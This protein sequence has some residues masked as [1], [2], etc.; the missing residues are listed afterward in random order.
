MSLSSEISHVHEPRSLDS[1]VTFRVNADVYNSTISLTDNSDSLINVF[2]KLDI[3][4][5][6]KVFTFSQLVNERYPN[7][8]L[9]V[10]NA[11]IGNSE[12]SIIS[13]W[14]KSSP[15][16]LTMSSNIRI[17]ALEPLQLDGEYILS[18]DVYKIGGS[19][20]KGST[21][22]S[23]VM[24]MNV[25]SGKSIQ[26][27]ANIVYPDRHIITNIEGTKN[28]NIYNAM[29]EMR[30]DADKNVDSRISV[31]GRG[32]ISGLN[33]INASITV[34]Y[35]RRTITFNVKH[36]LSNKMTSHIDFQWEQ[37]KL[38]VVDAA[39]GDYSKPEGREIIGSLKVATPFNDFKSMEA[40]V[41][42]RINNAMYK[43]QID[44]SWN[45]NKM[46]STTV[47][48]KKPF[49]IYNID[50][51]VIAKAT[52]LGFKTIQASLVHRINN[53]LHTVGKLN[54]NKQ[55]AQID[56][57]LS[58]K[59]DDIYSDIK[60]QVDIKTTFTDLREASA[61]FSHKNNGIQMTTDSKLQYNKQQYSLQSILSN[62][63]SVGHITVAIPDNVLRA[64]WTHSIINNEIVSNTNIT[65]GKNQGIYIRFNGMQEI[66]LHNVKLRSSVTVS[67]KPEQT[68][69][70]D[71]SF[72]RTTNN[73]IDAIISVILPSKQTV[74]L[75]AKK[76]KQNTEVMS[77]ASLEYKTGQIIRVESFH[78]L[79]DKKQIKLKFSSP[80]TND[81]TAEGIL[82]TSINNRMARVSIDAEPFLSKWSALATFDNTNGINYNLKI[83]TPYVQYA[84]SQITITSAMTEGKRQSTI[85]IEYLPG[86]HV[87]LSSIYYCNNLRDIHM[88]V[89]L[90][91]T[92]TQ[93]PYASVSFTHKGD[94]REFSSSAEME[95][96]HNTKTSGVITFSANDGLR[97]SV[98]IK[99]PFSADLS[100][101]F[102][103]KGSLNSFE[104]HGEIQWGQRY[105][106][107]LMHQGSLS[108]FTS[109]G[110]LSLGGDIYNGKLTFS[111][112]P[113]LS[114]EISIKTPIQRFE[115]IQLSHSFEG[116]LRKFS[117]HTELSS[118][119]YGTYISDIRLDTETGLAA[120][121]T[122]QTPIQ[123]Y[124]Y[125]KAALS[126]VG[127]LDK[128]VSH[129][130]V[131]NG[132]ISYAAD[133]KVSTDPDVNI[134]MSVETP[135]NEFKT[136][137]IS[138]SH[139][140]VVNDFK[141]QIET[142][143]NKDIFEMNLI[144]S[145][146]D[147]WDIDLVI[148]SPYMN[149]IKASFDHMG[150]KKK[151][152]SDFTFKY[153]KQNIQSNIKFQLDPS[154]NVVISLKSPFELFKHHELT[155]THA[156]GLDSFK[157]NMQYKCNGKT[158]IGD[159]SFQNLNT[160]RAEL[161]VKLPAFP[162]IN[163][164]V[165]HDGQPSNFKCL[166]SMSY[167]KNNIQ[168][169]T[170]FNSVNGIKG[171]IALKTPFDNMQSISASLSHSGHINNF[172]SQGEV[173]FNERIGRVD[174]TV[175][176]TKNIS[177]IVAIKTPFKGFEDISSTF[178]HTGGIYNFNS[179]VVYTLNGKR[180]EGQV[181]FKNDK[182]VSGSASLKSD[183]PY[184]GIYETLITYQGNTAKFN[185]HGSINM[186]KIVSEANI[187]FDSTNGYVGSF[188]IDS[189]HLKNIDMAFT[190]LFTTSSINSNA[191]ITYNG[192]KL[193]E[194]LVD[195]S[196]KSSVSGIVRLTTSHTG[197][198]ITE[199]SFN[200]NGNSH[201]VQ[202]DAKLQIFNENYEANLMLTSSPN[203]EAS[204]TIKSPYTE[205]VDLK[206]DHSSTYPNW[207]TVWD[208]S[209]GGQSMFN[210]D[211]S[212]NFELKVAGTIKLSTPLPGFSL[213]S[214]TFSHE[215]N[216][217]NFK[218]H[219][220]VT[221][222]TQSIIADLEYSPT[223]GGLT[224]STPF[225]QDIKGSFKIAG[226][227]LNSKSSITLNYGPTKLVQISAELNYP[228]F[229]ELILVTALQGYETSRVTISRQTDSD[230]GAKAEL[231]FRGQNHEA[232]IRLNLDREFSGSFVIA[233]PLLP[234]L[235]SRFNI[236]MKP[237][238]FHSHI[239]LIHDNKK[240]EV[241]TRFSTQKSI[242]GRFTAIS[243]L[244]SDFTVAFNT[245]T[246][247]ASLQSTAEASYG[248]YK[249]LDISSVLTIA[250]KMSFE[251]TAITPNIRTN[252]EM[253]LH[254]NLQDFTVH[255]KTTANGKTLEGD[256][257]VRVDPNIVGSL[258]IVTPFTHPINA[259]VS[260][261]GQSTNFKGFAEIGLMNKLSSCEVSLNTE[262]RID[263][264]FSL[265]S[266]YI[267]P[268]SAAVEHS[269][270]IN[271]F[272][273]HAEVTLD[274]EAHSV[275]ASFD[276]QGGLRNF[277]T[278]ASVA[279]DNERTEAKIMLDIETSMTGSA[280][281][282][283]PQNDKMTMSF[284][285]SGLIA[286]FKNTFMLKSNEQAIL[287][288]DITY[289]NNPL[290][291]SIVLKT[292]IRG[293]ETLSAKYTHEGSDL[294]FKSHAE[295]QISGQTTQCDISFN[296]G[297]KLEGK[298]S[299]KSPYFPSANIGFDFSGTF[300]KFESNA[301]L[302]Y[303]GNIYSIAT[304]VDTKSDIDSSVTIKTPI[305]GY[306]TLTGKLTH[307]GLYPNVN[308]FVQVKSGRRNLL[309]GSAKIGTNNGLN[310][311]LNGESVFTPTIQMKLDHSGTLS[312]FNCNGELR[313][314][315]QSHS[316]SIAFKAL[317][318][319]SGS[320]IISSPLHSPLSANFEVSATDDERILKADCILNGGK[321]S[322]NLSFVYN[323]DI[324][325]SLSINT[326][327]EHFTHIAGSIKYTR[328]YQGLKGIA[329][330]E[331][332][333]TNKYEIE[334]RSSWTQ[335]INHYV[336]IKSPIS[337]LESTSASFIFE[338]IF[339]NVKSDLTLMF[340]NR[341]YSLHGELQDFLSGQVTASLPFKGY[342]DLSFT[343]NRQGGINNMQT[344]MK[345]VYMT[346]KEMTASFQN[347]IT[348]KQMQTKAMLST[349]Y[350]ED[351]LFTFSHIG[352][353]NDFSN[354]VA[355]SMGDKNEISMT[356][357]FNQIRGRLNF[358][359]SLKTSFAGYSDEQ[360]VTMKYEGYLPN[361]KASANAKILGSFV[362][363]Q[364]SLQTETKIYGNFLLKTPIKD[365]AFT[366][367]HSG[368]SI[369]FNTKADI[370]YDNEHLKG[371]VQYSN[372]GWRRLETSVEVQ[373]PFT[374]FE[375]SKATFRHSGSA[376]TIQC[377]SFM[378]IYKKDFTASLLASMEPL[379][380]AV[381]ITTP[382]SGF[383]QIGTNLK[384]NRAS[385]IFNGEASVNYMNGK[386]VSLASKFD[387][388]SSPKVMNLKFTTP[389]TGYESA[390]IN[391]SH[392]GNLY[393]FQSTATA[394]SSFASPI[395]MQAGLRYASFFSMDGSFALTS[396]ISNIENIRFLINNAFISE[397]YT[398]RI[399]TSWTSAK[400]IIFDGSFIGDKS[401]LNT[402]VTITTPFETIRQINIKSLAEM[403]NTRYSVKLL[404]QYNSKTALD[405]DL[406]SVIGQRNSLS[407]AIRSPIELTVVIDGAFIEKYEGALTVSYSK[408]KGYRLTGSF[409]PNTK[410]LIAKYNSPDTT[411]SCDGIFD[412]MNTKLNVDIDGMR[413]GYDMVMTSTDTM[414]KI[415]SPSRSVKVVAS[416]RSGTTEAFFF[417]D[418]DKDETRK[419]GF[420]STLIPSKESIKADVTLMMPSFGKVI[421]FVVI[422]V[423][424]Y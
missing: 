362:S 35:L 329:T 87:K 298:V 27:S 347:T 228:Q 111:L 406:S 365:L 102:R 57:V 249:L 211:V 18:P 1:K 331:L 291:G 199:L 94:L 117:D 189:P 173:N 200:H 403:R 103:H 411:I 272:K 183:I 242:E 261:D 179:L 227:M 14:K 160:R 40:K 163:I 304:T 176:L 159:A 399:E 295:L 54:W 6:G 414:T 301:E 342:E 275:D 266:P 42:H 125:V 305:N 420:R 182:T 20:Q 101:S 229:A 424:F 417:W 352:Q 350:T 64:Q 141:L 410:S 100:G 71:G 376:N 330:F 166:A 308:S 33:N 223:Q 146:K 409:D 217:N 162:A 38:V 280:T 351:I 255:I 355:F 58:N 394:T 158:Y 244:I 37:E 129:A 149:T 81:L 136:S 5:P 392:D 105:E 32:Q 357:T 34:Q 36:S 405:L 107:D 286:G 56:I 358:D 95:Y 353:R 368:N 267:M 8:F 91:T 328:S 322:L 273:C 148:R 356:T 206:V 98:N 7:E 382:I 317:P 10:T 185:I 112:E 270:S 349:P 85:D 258:R 306:R 327:I 72:N 174:V 99:T 137:R 21:K 381:A 104:S 364:S 287:N 93:M 412:K 121:I 246:D 318:N 256:A 321:Y 370:Q 11:T 180:S 39:L 132:L 153:G 62:K 239:E 338:G 313:F 253:S 23:S 68:L 289:S 390:E 402:A 154:L 230:M 41:N 61:S 145:I 28:G 16:S 205:T 371:S 70:I 192:A 4:V 202:S 421:Y 391:V 278:S 398:S 131:K 208:I 65:W 51:E 195:V 215:G 316:A 167:G 393:N 123:E 323:N 90:T 203:I 262:E 387:M 15:F 82:D 43:S 234:Q 309:T 300:D 226:S 118:S 46:I 29:A 359:S 25:I 367:E 78:S 108:R 155:I 60:G 3:S 175:D 79:D 212:L 44:V 233:T 115:N 59:G 311:Q 416:K 187:D 312:N 127:T 48:L 97:G 243:P 216:L 343:Y 296:I 354:I 135:F 388:N 404:A 326:P 133:L 152:Q 339:P 193:Y 385:G 181:S 69:T 236:E 348:D 401:S 419:I 247:T 292:P 375:I 13:T 332:S 277:Q 113:K 423:I 214:T 325:A 378:S 84:Y 334:A 164:V 86:K 240:H 186:N 336:S 24:L 310:V 276:H 144:S 53:G 122:I 170:S 297:S 126:H 320:F 283:L 66:N 2:G 12:N 140:G 89:E 383:E 106:V 408:N 337:S 241:K 281:L 124:S 157:C 120:D 196:T 372:Y 274:S 150:S 188:S 168:L 109:N 302:G 303:D 341:R 220:E 128:F 204:I 377:D 335:G 254:G 177:A 374:G 418:A 232:D 315:E 198:E 413:Y 324:G 52:A 360:K 147:K 293:Y 225:T 231:V 92:F 366:M 238:N 384:I 319:L 344:N 369:N 397:K 194:L 165:S 219:G 213:L 284:E 210:F 361:F 184:V 80:F 282:T 178:K 314:N 19:L 76:K 307:S 333:P 114:T 143:I 373:T 346:G 396:Q 31:N 96:P 9:S 257:S 285:H 63:F 26:L 139:V 248:S 45:P 294:N 288:F 134:D 47:T 395:R 88:N 209:Y 138:L 250:D 30:W 222:E 260:F 77:S 224:V 73:D 259:R 268:V 207:N 252:L 83:N 171:S 130:E 245:N 265:K 386:T 269:G 74:T 151:F 22:Y 345:I 201:S 110:I 380:A 363:L 156:G 172:K 218:C 191:H 400:K 49:A 197:Y 221:I 263:A 340:F 299:V 264:K 67:L 116:N 119:G 190:H 251:I 379:S 415:I 279:F 290:Q 271:S 235:S 422:L 169:D 55:S 237:K 17:D 407:V 161:N 389:Y 75:S 50:A 142:Q